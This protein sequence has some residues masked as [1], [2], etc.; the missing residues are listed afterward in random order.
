MVVRADASLDED[1]IER[2]LVG[3]YLHDISK[4]SL[5]NAAQE[6][7]LAK[8][9]EAGVYA[10][11]LLGTG[12]LPAGMTQMG[13]KRVAASGDRAM[14]RFIRANLRLVVSIARRYIRKGGMPF[15]DLIQEGNLGLVRA[16]MKFDYKR[17]Y[18]FS[19]YATWW[20]RQAITRGIAEQERTIRLPVHIMEK[21]NAMRNATRQLVRKLG[22]DPEPEQIAAAMNVPVERVLK[23]IDLTQDMLSLDMPVGENGIGFGNTVG[24]LDMPTPEEEVIARLDRENLNNLL[25]CLETRS[26]NVMRARFGLDDGRARSLAELA[27]LFSVSRERIRQ[28]ENKALADLSKMAQA[29]L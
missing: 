22:S 24:D 12:N 25:G 29:K 17:G 8:A 19:T 26:A 7:A 21:V 5:L 28:I 1:V 9:I 11:H 18:K 15:L 13:L 4:I 14:D 3:Q 16:V 2:D 6:V 27:E 10:R 20:I 23:L